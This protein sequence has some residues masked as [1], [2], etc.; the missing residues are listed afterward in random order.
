MTVNYNIEKQGGLVE[1]AEPL[2]IIT[3]FEKLPASIFRTEDE[4]AKYVALKVAEYINNHSGPRPFV[5]GLS[6]GQT[7]VGVYRKLSQLY[8]D[9]KGGFQPRRVLPYRPVRA[10]E[11]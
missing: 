9:G 5:L 7:P 1:G 2:D 4:G 10:A 3:R 11:P 8:R 6:T